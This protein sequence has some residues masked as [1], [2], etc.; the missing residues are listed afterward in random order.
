ML[1]GNG[2]EEV[3]TR[4]QIHLTVPPRL[5]IVPGTA[6]IVGVAIGLMRGGRA[7]S[8]RFLAENAHR[9]PST[10][11]GWY[12]YNKTKNYKVIL[13]GLKGAGVDASKLGLMGLGW[14]GIEEGMERLGWGECKEIGAALGTGAVFCGVCKWNMIVKMGW[15]T[16]MEKNRSIRLEDIAKNAIACIDCRKRV[17]DFELE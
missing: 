1:Q 11:Q 15:K 13:G 2:D 14:V 7:A 17:E 9:P 10:V 16:D 4:R 6:I 12:F 3:A 8:L 5:V